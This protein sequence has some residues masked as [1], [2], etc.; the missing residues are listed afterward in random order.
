MG[1][2][3]VGVGVA[4]DISDVRAGVGRCERTGCAWVGGT[5]GDGETSGSGVVVVVTTECPGCSRLGW[6]PLCPG[7]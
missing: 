4:V 6:L 5:V 3:E 7:V 1:G 2:G